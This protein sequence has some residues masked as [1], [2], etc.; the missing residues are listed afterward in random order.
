MKWVQNLQI[1]PLNP[2]HT[3]LGGIL[4]SSRWDMSRSICAQNLAFL[5][6]PVQNLW[7]GVQNLQIWPL[8]PTTPHLGNFAILVNI[9]PCTKF[10]VS[11]L[12]SRPNFGRIQKFIN[13]A[14]GPH[15]APFWGIFDPQDGTCQGLSYTK[16]KISNLTR[17][18]FRGFVMI[19]TPASSTCGRGTLWLCWLQENDVT[20]PGWFKGPTSKGREWKRRR[21]G[22]ERKGRG[23]GKGGEEKGGQGVEGIAPPP[24]MKS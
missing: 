1:L 16:F 11:I 3:A 8:N 5:A 4:L 17:Y 14:H 15:R 2:Y 23:E 7:N 21:R 13:S 22:R 10:E 20:R 18:K 12:P 19:H 6:T 9:Y 24:L